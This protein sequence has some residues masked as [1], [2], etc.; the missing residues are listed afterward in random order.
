MNEKKQKC[1]VEILFDFVD[2]YASFRSER[3]IASARQRAAS[4]IEKKK[5]N[6][7]EKGRREKNEKITLV[8]LFSVITLLTANKQL[9]S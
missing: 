8:S 9:S 3:L 2:L 5:K 7:R 1:V 4:L 6:E